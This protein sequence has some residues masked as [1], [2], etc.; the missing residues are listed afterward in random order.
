MHCDGGSRGNPGPSGIGFVIE[1]D[2]G[3]GL[4]VLADGGAFIG[5]ATNNQAEYHALLWGLR[6]AAALGIRSLDIHADSELM[7]KQL[8]GVYKVRNAGIKPL[9]E[10]ARGLLTGFER[11]QIE[12]VRRADNS[13][14]D[15]LANQAMDYAGSVGTYRMDYDYTGE[16]ALDA[17]TS[18][19]IA[20]IGQGEPVIQIEPDEPAVQVEPSKPASRPVLGGPEAHAGSENHGFPVASEYPGSRYTL[21][22]RDHFDAAHALVG[23]PGECQRLHGHTWDVE[24]SVCGR[25]L[26]E[27]GIVYDFKT[28]KADL[29]A[30]LD[31]YDHTYL[32]DREPF[33]RINAT[34]ENLARV[35]YHRLKPA[36]PK[37]IDLV[38]VAVWESPIAKIS[39]R[40]AP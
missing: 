30:I 24:V 6:N 9:Y 21:S 29:A 14:A 12:H 27:V 35:I 39:Y 2:T 7:V 26:D 37:G 17:G 36:L 38:E 19:P 25:E 3:A 40:E 16:P 13:R 34:A 18:K 32:N 11:W 15:A 22:V 28:L 8:S 23:Y 4:E 33:D 5:Q 20:H 1:I 10:Q 31:D